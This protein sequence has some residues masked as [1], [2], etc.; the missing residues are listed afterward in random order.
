MPRIADPWP[1]PDTVT[2]VRVEEVTFPSGSPF[3]PADLGPA[4]GSALPGPP[5][6]G[7]ERLYLPQHPGADRRVPAVVF[8]HG[9]A[10]LVPQRGD[11]YGRQLAGMGIA[12][13]VVDTFGVFGEG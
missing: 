13:L 11:T 5:T 4:D 1:D 2:G 7:L 10:G 12:V 8:L 3:S 6:Q 9:A